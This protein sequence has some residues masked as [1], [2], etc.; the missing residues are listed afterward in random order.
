MPQVAR[1]SRSLDAQCVLFYDIDT[2]A[3][4]LH[5][6]QVAIALLAGKIEAIFRLGL[7]TDVV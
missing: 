3:V 2:G 1:P 5:R 7:L 4:R 6:V